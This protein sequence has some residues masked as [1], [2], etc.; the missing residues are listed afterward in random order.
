MKDYYVYAVLA[1]FALTTLPAMSI[2]SPRKASECREVCKP[3]SVLE[4]GRV[5]RCWPLIPAGDVNPQTVD[6][7]HQEHLQN[8]D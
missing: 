7:E 6:K 4:C 2:L 3:G 8:K 1:A 5:I